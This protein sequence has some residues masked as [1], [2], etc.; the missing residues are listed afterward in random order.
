MEVIV[1]TCDGTGAAINVILGKHPIKVK[2]MNMED[3]G[4]LYPVLDWNN[5]M[6][7]I[8]AVDEGIKHTGTT[9]ADRAAVAANG[10]SLYNGGDDI[11][12]DGATN[13]RWEDSDG[14]SVEEKYVDGYYQRAAGGGAAYKCYG[15][16]T[17]PGGLTDGAKVKTAPGFTIGTD[18]D[19]NVDGEQ[20]IW[21]AWV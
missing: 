14:N 15:D 10:I 8:S 19:I 1:G 13:M 4:T 16:K 3:A 7:L 6:A 17:V 5:Q 12:Y 18:A 20:L 2:V 9:D 21:E 11:V